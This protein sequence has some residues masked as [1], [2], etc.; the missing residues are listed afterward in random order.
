[1][2]AD[3][4]ANTR[5]NFAFLADKA[6]SLNGK[7]YVMGGCFD[8]IQVAKFPTLHAVTIVG[9]IVVSHDDGV[10]EHTIQ[11][12]ISG[13]GDPKLTTKGIKLRRNQPLP[14]N[15]QSTFAASTFT[16]LS[17]AGRYEISVSLDE[18]EP[19]LMA[20]VAEEASS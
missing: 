5:I 3:P 9:A 18:Q 19:W 10:S 20:F 4:A 2:D 17:Q 15:V 11:F 8:R 14:T 6:E 13:P 7:L 12:G 16:A 1:M